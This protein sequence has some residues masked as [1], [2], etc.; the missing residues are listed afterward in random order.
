MEMLLGRAA[1]R[2]IVAALYQAGARIV[3]ALGLCF[4]VCD[5][6][7]ERVD[8][9]AC[10]DHENVRCIGDLTDRREVADR[11]VTNWSLNALFTMYALVA[12]RSV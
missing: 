5:K 9:E 11:I 7:V 6:L 8:A 12:I 1:I 4:R 10:V 3:Y 2:R